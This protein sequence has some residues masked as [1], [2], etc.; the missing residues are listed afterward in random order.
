MGNCT[1][2]KCFTRE[3]ERA[4]EI[5]ADSSRGLKPNI[6]NPH[7]NIKTIPERDQNERIKS[8]LEIKDKAYY[9]NLMKNSN[10]K[11]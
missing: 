4:S 7:E 9:N 1:C 8:T 6:D 5:S 2:K 3:N 11:K 10:K